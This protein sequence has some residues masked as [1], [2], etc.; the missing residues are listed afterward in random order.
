M[1][2][3]PHLARN[4][5]K[6]LERYARALRHEPRAKVLEVAECPPKSQCYE[7]EPITFGES[8]SYHVS[9][10]HNDPLVIEVQIG[11]MM[12]ARVMID[13]EASSNIMFKQALLRMGLTLE[14]L[15]PCEQLMYGF[16]RVSIPLCGKIKL[17]LTVDIAPK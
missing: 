7:C 15:E 14:D 11:T 8:E 12:V 9:Y 1:I 3:G 6:A 16:N 4:S 2:G 17:P 5:R 10:S 13:D